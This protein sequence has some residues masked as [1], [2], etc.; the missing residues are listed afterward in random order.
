MSVLAD[1]LRAVVFSNLRG[2][3]P[4]SIRQ[5]A[6]DLFSAIDSDLDVAGY[7]PS[8]T[9]DEVIE[10]FD[11]TLRRGI[12]G[13]DDF[14]PYDIEDVDYGDDDEEDSVNLFDNL[15]DDASS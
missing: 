10:K 5:A 4:K 3:V 8:S 2:D 15:D 12:E 1:K 14:S 7:I 6:W 11:E 13:D 9:T